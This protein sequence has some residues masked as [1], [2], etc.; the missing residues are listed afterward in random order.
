MTI[1]FV[2]HKMPV[3]FGIARRILVMHQGFLIADGEPEVVRRDEKV[4]KAYLGEN[5]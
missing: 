4:Q 5:V 2:E 1:L 3:V